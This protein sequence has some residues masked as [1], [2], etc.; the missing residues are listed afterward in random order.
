MPSWG[1]SAYIGE[2]IKTV[3]LVSFSLAAAQSVS[4]AVKKF[5]VDIILS[6]EDLLPRTI[7]SLIEL[8]VGTS[9][10]RRKK[11]KKKGR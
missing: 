10:R 6:F 2:V 8:V 7:L 4:S 3:L 9:G 11:V 5:L 1:N